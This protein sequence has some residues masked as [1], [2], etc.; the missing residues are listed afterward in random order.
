MDVINLYNDA[1]CLIGYVFI[2][3]PIPSVSAVNLILIK[4]ISSLYLLNTIPIPPTI[5]CEQSALGI[6][7]TK[8][9]LW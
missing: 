2:S 7:A 8:K 4:S 6:F 9:A 5:L 1:N 3:R